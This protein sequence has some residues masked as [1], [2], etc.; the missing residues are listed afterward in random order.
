MESV[1]ELLLGFIKY[2]TETFNFEENVVSISQLEPLARKEKR[3]TASTLICIEDPFEK[4][5]N[6]GAGLTRRSKTFNFF[7]DFLEKDSY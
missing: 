5:H 4:S 1:G 6:L 2:Y 3:W 7:P